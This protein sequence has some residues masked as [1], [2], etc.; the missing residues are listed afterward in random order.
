MHIIRFKF[1]SVVFFEFLPCY[2]L[3]LSEVNQFCDLA[4]LNLRIAEPETYSSFVSSFKSLNGFPWSL[5]FLV[6]MGWPYLLLLPLC[7]VSIACIS[8]LVL[9]TKMQFMGRYVKHPKFCF[10]TRAL[11]IPRLF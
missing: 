8:I 5:M 10:S 7:N 2:V 6:T 9:Q 3:L 11:I 1:V 4:K